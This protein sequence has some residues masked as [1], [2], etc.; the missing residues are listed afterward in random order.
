MDHAPFRFA[1]KDLGSALRHRANKAKS[2]K[3]SSLGDFCA[4][5]VNLKFR[6]L[7]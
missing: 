6:E 5:A 7:A 1:W 4:L 2:Q 3:F